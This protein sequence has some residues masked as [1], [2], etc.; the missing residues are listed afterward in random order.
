MGLHP[1]QIVLGYEEASKKV[2]SL[3]NEDSLVSKRVVDPRNLVEVSSALRATVASKIPNYA[4]F[5]SNLVARAC[6]NSLPDSVLNFDIDNIRVIHILGSSIDDSTL[7]SGFLVK[8]N[9]EGCI[10]RMIKP[11]IAVFSC[12]LD[13]MQSETKGTVLIQNAKELLNYSKGEEDLAEKFVAQLVNANINVVV[14]GGSVSDIV[15]HFMDKYKIMV[16]KILS[17]FELRRVARAVRATILSELKAPTPEEV[18]TSDDV[19]VE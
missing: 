8:R 3:L 11:R 4:D 10:D 5:F 1:S 13:T 15:L 18:G 9:A 12:P 16:V 14:S 7:L 2:L 6:I 17:K 19:G